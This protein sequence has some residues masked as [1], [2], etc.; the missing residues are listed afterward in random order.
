MHCLK[1]RGSNLLEEKGTEVLPLLFHITL[2]P[3]GP[4]PIFDTLTVKQVRCALVTNLLEPSEQLPASTII[5][6]VGFYLHTGSKGQNRRFTVSLIPKVLQAAWVESLGCTYATCTAA[7]KCKSSLPQIIYLR[8]RDSPG[9]GV[10]DVLS[11][12]GLEL[13]L[14]PY[15]KML[16]SQDIPQSFLRTTSKKSG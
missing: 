10:E 8:H 13:S 5:S 11:W 3:Q 15:L 14:C 16:H 6:C 9:C 7:W 4:T 12:T 1:V 2:D